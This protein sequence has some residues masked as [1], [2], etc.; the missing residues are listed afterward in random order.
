MK[1]P[2]HQTRQIPAGAVEHQDGESSAVVYCY[3]NTV[4]AKPAA[5]AFHGRAKVPDWQYYFATEERRAAKIAEFFTQIRSWEKRQIERR[6]QIAGARVTTPQAVWEK[7]RGGNSSLSAAETAVCVRAVIARAFPGVK[8]SVT[9]DNYSMGCSVDVHWTD[10]PRQS[11]VDKILSNFS[12]AGFDGMIDLKYNKSRWL[13][14]NGEMSLAHSEGTEGSRGSCPEAIGDPPA[15]DCVLVTN[16]A[17]YV[18]GQ[19]RLSFA[20]ELALARAVCVHYGHPLPPACADS[21]ELWRWL[22][23]QCVT[24]SNGQKEYLNGLINRFDYDHFAAAWNAGQSAAPGIAAQ[25]I[26]TAATAAKSSFAV[27]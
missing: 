27:Y 20:Y 9:S 25:T 12:F 11:D 6:A 23:A 18:H 21:N 16:G 2:F 3:P 14:P 22:N 4:N 1:N 10:G 17:D 5:V 13:R 7:V 26:E 19:R 24:W 8:F 15:P